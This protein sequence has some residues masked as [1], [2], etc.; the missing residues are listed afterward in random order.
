[1]RSI[2]F[3]RTVQEGL[4]KKLLKGS[5]IEPEKDGEQNEDLSGGSEFEDATSEFYTDGYYS[6]EET[7]SGIISIP[8]EPINTSITPLVPHRINTDEE[9]TKH[10]CWADSD[11][12]SFSDG[13]SSEDDVDDA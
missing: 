10:V 9:P 2:P 8:A 13:S 7:T 3:L 5:T 11:Q 4:D 12:D 1:M 6:A